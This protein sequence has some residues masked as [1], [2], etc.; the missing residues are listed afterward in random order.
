MLCAFK[1]SLLG[2]NGRFAMQKQRQASGPEVRKGEKKMHSAE[3]GKPAGQ[4]SAVRA[5]QVQPKASPP[6]VDQSSVGNVDKIREILFGSQMRDFE[7]R[8]A[9]L[10]QALAEATANL[11]ESTYKRLETLEQHFTKELEALES[12]QKS[13]REDRVETAR[14][15]AQEMKQADEIRHRPRQGVGG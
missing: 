1:E 14:K 13:E 2:G 4:A 8:M 6:E 3:D 10:E 5:R 9:R 12:R 15:L 11:R 7:T